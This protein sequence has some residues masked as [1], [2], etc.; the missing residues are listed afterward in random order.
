MNKYVWPSILGLLIGI[1]PA[2]AEPNNPFLEENPDLSNLTE[3]ESL[4]PV[5]N[6]LNPESSEGFELNEDSMTQVT[7]VS[8]L[9]DVQPSD[10]AYEALRNLVERYGCIAGYPDGTF[11]GNRALTRYEFAAGLNACLQQI[12]RLAGGIP[13][14]DLESLRRLMTEFEA[15]LAAIAARVDNL[16]G[17]VAFL[18]DHQ[19]STTVIMGGETIFALSVAGGG[20][21]P[22]S[23]EAQTTLNYLSR[24]QFVTS[25]YGKDRLRLELESGNFD[26]FHFGEPDVLNTNTALMSFQSSTGN[27]EL[28]SMLEYRFATLGDRVVFTVRP[29]GFSLSSVLT[30][31]SPFF[32][33]GRGS[34]SRYGEASPIFKIGALDAG[35]GMD[36]L[37]SDRVR[38][39][40]AHGSRN[41]NDPGF[42]GILGE[43]A[44]S[45]GVQLLLLP[46]ENLLT[47]ITYVYGYSPN[48][49][50]NT[51]TGS[52]IADAS[53]YI[54]QK[55]DIHAISGT[56]QWRI[57]PKVT[58]STWGGIVG[59]IGRETEAYAVSTNYMF[60]LGVYDLFQEGNLLGLMFGQPP[61]LIEYDDIAISSGLSD[62][63]TSFH[64]E[65]FYRHKINDN[66]FITPGV[67]FVTNPGNIERNNTIWVGTIRTTFRF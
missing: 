67:F 27:D 10:W 48:G 14:E 39:Q 49:R 8:Q 53:G 6:E 62:D 40:V 12:E 59:T 45:T 4:D 58:F 34:I 20:D 33:S 60:S 11:R 22:G 1:N 29:V 47:G 56:L 13:T 35:V 52:A 19:F 3:L 57:S 7:N 46:N 31:N 5:E 32:D 66:I 44:H 64:I 42:G 2:L 21:P 43:D 28:L 26:R 38:L 63:A 23:G 51:F 25:F 55:S 50:L 61:K 41:A 36:W 9:R 30:A 65:A 18:E 16:E 15:E 24:L 37:I 17:R 54:N